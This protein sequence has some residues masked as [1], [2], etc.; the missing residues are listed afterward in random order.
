M[1]ELYH[2]DVDVFVCS[3][4]SCCYTN[5]D[6]IILESS[7]LRCC[8]CARIVSFWCQCICMLTIQMLLY[9][10]GLY[11]PWYLTIKGLYLW[12]PIG[13][14][15]QNIQTGHP[16][17]NPQKASKVSKFHRKM[18][19]RNTQTLKTQINTNLLTKYKSTATVCLFV[20]C[21]I[22][23]QTFLLISYQPITQK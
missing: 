9:K 8:F 2:F 21:L 16:F 18:L 7:Q 4:F 3:Q 11:H 20:S 14:L 10:L 22:S 5:L 6:C 15:I 19:A 17:S 12:V 23:I 1:Q 13:S